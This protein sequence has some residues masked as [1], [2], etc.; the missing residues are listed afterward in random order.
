M[1]LQILHT[2]LP[3]IGPG[4]IEST[5]ITLIIISSIAPEIIASIGRVIIGSIAFICINSIILKNIG[6]IA[7]GVKTW[8]VFL[9]S[10]SSILEHRLEC[11]HL[12]L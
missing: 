1:K 6:D 4:R 3:Y 10:G 8:P 9:K 5:G 2:S 12:C 7:L 11:L